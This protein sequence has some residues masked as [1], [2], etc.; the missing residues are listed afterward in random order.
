MVEGEPGERGAEDHGEA[1]DRLQTDHE[2]ALPEAWLEASDQDP[3]RHDGTQSHESEEESIR[4]R[5]PPEPD[6]AEEREVVHEPG[7]G[8]VEQQ[9]HREQGPNVSHLE[10]AGQL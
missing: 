4:S 3:L 9:H 10:Y 1:E 6:L 7:E 8:Q 5:P 2:P